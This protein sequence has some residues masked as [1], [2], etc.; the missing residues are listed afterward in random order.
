MNSHIDLT[1]P[2]DFTTILLNI[3]VMDLPVNGGGRDRGNPM[4]LDTR[5]QQLIDRTEIIEAKHAFLRAAD[6]CDADRM[7]AGFVEDLTASYDP[8]GEPIRGRDSLRDWY[9]SRLGHVVASSHHASNFEVSFDD[10]D[11]AR[12]RCY[13][14]S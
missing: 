13:L 5:L 6:A 8:A 11:T 14:Y 7:V 1:A 12:L 3:I 4:E 9:A 10:P 2:F